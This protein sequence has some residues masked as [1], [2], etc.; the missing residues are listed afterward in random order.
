MNTAVFDGRGFA[1]GK[2]NKLKS[3]VKKLR[4]KGIKP[5]LVSILVGEDPASA[6]YVNL[7]RSAA[8]RVGAEVEIVKLQKGEKTE[9]LKDIIK[10][11]NKNKAVHGIMVQLPL[12]D[13][14][15]L[16]AKSIINAISPEKDVDGLREDSPY[17]TP[18]VKAVLAALEVGT[19]YIT[20]SVLRTVVAGAGGFEGKKIIKA[21]SDMGYDV[22]GLGRET[23][24]LATYTK[25][26]DILISVTGQEGLI[27]KDMVK[28]G[29]LIIDVGSPKGDVDKNAY[30]KAS[31]VSPVPGGIGPVTISCLLENL[32]ETASRKKI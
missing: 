27:R 17:I 2:E 31:F 3:E 21:L 24:D 13:S 9:K 16:E 4:S 7:K 23:K 14:L 20:P 5:K 30:G 1:K 32:V 11:Y 12:P 19:K 8:E 18:V 10:K 6:L 28:K 25:Q 15:K 22:F 29:A 26:A